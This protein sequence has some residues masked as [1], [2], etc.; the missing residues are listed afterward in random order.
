MAS[1]S[2]A[3]SILALTEKPRQ[4]SIRQP[5]AVQS[6]NFSDFSPLVGNALTIIVCECIRMD[7]RK[8]ES[9]NG[10]RRRQRSARQFSL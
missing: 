2:T 7:T 10:Q 1:E 9:G 5:G 3:P 4:V 6:L 8:I